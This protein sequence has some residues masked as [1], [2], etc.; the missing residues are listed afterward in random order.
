MTS[1]AVVALKCTV[2]GLDRI[3]RGQIL[4]AVYET[5]T[6]TLP[7][8]QK[9]PML[10]SAGN[11]LQAVNTTSGDAN[12]GFPK[13]QAVVTAEAVTLYKGQTLDVSVPIVV[14]GKTEVLLRESKNDTSTL[15]NNPKTVLPGTKIYMEPVKTTTVLSFDANKTF[16]GTTVHSITA[17]THSV[18]LIVNFAQ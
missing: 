11:D 16:L 6:Q 10:N 1:P 17:T 5:A 13:Y 3:D 8:L 7:I 2:R 18:D 14:L 4:Y 15:F 12:E 9:T